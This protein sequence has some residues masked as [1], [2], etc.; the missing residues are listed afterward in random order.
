MDVSVFIAARNE[1]LRI[2]EQLDAL[3]RQDFEGEW[4][5]V[6]ADNGSTDGTAEVVA[7][8]SQVRPVVR[9]VDASAKADRSYALNTAVDTSDAPL[10]VFTDADDVVVDGW[11]SAM[12]RGLADA[13]VVTGPEELDRLNPKWLA[14]SRGRGDEASRGS[15]AGIFPTVR[16][17]NYGVQAAT[18]QR[19]GGLRE[20]SFPCD[21][22]DLSFRCWVDGIE[23]VGL[24]DAIVHYRYRDT[25][26]VLWRQG[27]SYGESRV[28]LARTLKDAERPTP[29][30]FGG[31]R[32]WVKLVA[33]LPSLRSMEGRATWAWVAGNRIGQLVGSVRH[34]LVML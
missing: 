18:W 26:K 4:E 20:G 9:L 34:R 11:L 1:E 12:V 10:F 30:R 14:D 16:G 32:S 5:V 21:D 2:G 33:T 6:V 31:W 19:L 13:E 23:I 17:N 15:Y 3:L 29:P 27:K 28:R 8:Y 22:L 25:A 7:R 24:P